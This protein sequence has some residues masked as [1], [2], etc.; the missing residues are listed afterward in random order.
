MTADIKN[1][2]YLMFY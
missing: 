1:E 2:K